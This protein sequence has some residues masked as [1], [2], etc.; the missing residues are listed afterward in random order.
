MNCKKCGFKLDDG[1]NFCGS[2]GT[3]VEESNLV[4]E[5]V[6][7]S[8]DFSN[9][10][11]KSSNL[12]NVIIIFLI[13]FIMGGIVF[14]GYSLLFNNKSSVEKI[15]YALN[16]MLDMNG[17]KLSVNMDISTNYD[18]QDVSIEAGADSIIDVKN[19]LASVD[20]NASLTGVSINVPAYIDMND[21]M[22]YLKVPTDNN[23]YKMSI[24]D[25][26]G[27]DF[28]SFDF[29]N[30]RLVFE[31]Y[32]RNDDFIEKVSSDI[33]GTDKYILHFTK[34]VLME[35]SNDETN[36]FDYSSL[37]E[38]GFSDGF[39]MILY[40]NK[41]ENYVNRIVF[42]FSSKTFSDIT[43]DKFIFSIDITDVNKIESISIPNEALNAELLD[44]A[45]FDTD[46]S[47]D[48]Y[49][50]D[51]RLS[52][53]NH[54]INYQLPEG[55]EA[56]NVNSSNFKI[57]RNN[58]M[59]VIM[60]LDYDNRDS[61]FENVNSEMESAVELGYTDINLS[62]VKELNYDDKTFYYKELTYTTT[63]G[64]NNYE[65]YMCYVIDNDFVYSI[66]FEDDDNNGSVTEDSMKKFLNFTLE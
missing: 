26:T 61:F 19:R 39:E 24:A 59:R 22:V 6:V 21:N 46:I 27:L 20:V 43:F 64:T 35:L 54:V 23:W 44:T 56:S 10:S 55:S 51:Y 2:C 28:N 8:N 66:T 62:D 38:Y 13:C 65:V 50:E 31:D 9:A 40:V 47:D 16:N 29:E 34:D 18:G 58:G 53:Y 30:K 48:G 25:T 15:E 45:D 12:K 60:T 4:N 7:T 63:Y 36:D 37:E 49:V 17:F 5:T 57:Y 52:Y 11:N 1:A 33:D 14:L 42:D 3:K 32:L 41:K